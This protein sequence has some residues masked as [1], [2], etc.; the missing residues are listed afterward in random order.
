MAKLRGISVYD[1][2]VAM[3]CILGVVNAS[4]CVC[5][6]R[7]SQALPRPPVGF[8]GKSRK[9]RGAGLWKEKEGERKKGEGIVGR[10]GRGR[11]ENLG[12]LTVAQTTNDGYVPDN[13]LFHFR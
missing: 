1:P 12:S 6:G 7:A 5:W 10:E 13:M 11:R 4:K 3:G 9:G 8:R 2:V